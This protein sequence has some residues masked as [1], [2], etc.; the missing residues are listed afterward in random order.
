MAVDNPSLYDR[1]VQTFRQVVRLNNDGTLDTT[2]G[3]GGVVTQVIPIAEASRLGDG[4]VVVGADGSIFVLRVVD[5]TGAPIDP[6]TSPGVVRDIVVPGGSFVDPGKPGVFAVTKLK[7]HGAP[8]T[9]YGTA[10]TATITTDLRVASF[11]GLLPTGR[12]YADG[13][14]ILGGVAGVL[15][16][17]DNF[18]VPY[19]VKVTPLV[20]SQVTS[21]ALVRRVVP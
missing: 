10:G 13:S 17:A 1:A 11:S 20:Q 5:S 7:P 8:D 9:G 21:C 16:D 3:S 6:A 4:G 14:L 19:V 2:Y 15:R 18:S 12:A